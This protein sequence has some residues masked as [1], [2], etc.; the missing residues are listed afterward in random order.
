MRVPL[1]GAIAVAGLLGLTTP[2]LAT[3][4]DQ[5][6]H[7]CFTPSCEVAVAATRDGQLLLIDPTNGGAYGHLDHRSPSEWA[8][9]MT[10]PITAISMADD[11]AFYSVFDFEETA[12]NI[13]WK[14]FDTSNPP[15]LAVSG[16]APA[17]SPDGQFLAYSF[18]PGGPAYGHGTSSIAVRDVVSGEVRT[19]H[20]NPD[21]EVVMVDG[22]I[23]SIAWSP[24]STRLA[25]HLYHREAG[26][27]EPTHR[28]YVLD[29]VT[30]RSLSDARYLGSNSSP[31]WNADF[32]LA[33]VE[34]CCDPAPPQTGPGR[35]GATGCIP[36]TVVRINLATGER[37][38]VWTTAGFP[39]P[40]EAVDRVAVR[41]G[42][43][44]ELLI[45]RE[46]SGG[47]DHVLPGGAM[48]RVGS[49]YAA[50]DW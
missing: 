34:Q 17:L 10:P 5:L 15:E 45:V 1:A 11:G 46:A 31:T 50:V 37:I 22:F 7:S 39:L 41:D 25:Y 40:D 19:F 49:G 18:Q 24:D 44:S 47:L 48:R 30:G 9:E 36:G 33:A 13:W 35:C 27:S 28:L 16:A 21:D 32:G 6:D 14:A 8:P 23:D 12:Y 42:F 26:E 2:A 43:G 29:L 20:P 4:D 38:P 3:V